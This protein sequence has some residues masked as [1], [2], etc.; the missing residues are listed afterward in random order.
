M[1][2][3][4]PIAAAGSVAATS[5]TTPGARLA[6]ARIAQGLPVEGVAQQLKFSARQ[7]EALEADRYEQLPGIAVVRGMVRGYARLVG[8]EAEPLLEKALKFQDDRLELRRAYV[9]RFSKVLPGRQ[10]ARFY[11]IENK[12][13][14]V[15]RYELAVTV[16]SPDRDCDQ[17]ANWWEVVSPDLTRA[18][19]RRARLRNADLRRVRLANADLREADLTGART[20][21]ADLYGANFSGATWTDGRT[22]CADP[23][24]GQ[25]NPG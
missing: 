17:Y 15:L 21:D 5:A 20:E 23:S 8:V 11:Q 25:C 19:L 13:D 7:I 3:P 12:I 6:Q 24:I 2:D 22:R 9:A 1:T 14:A 4:A 10:L 16:K 18:D